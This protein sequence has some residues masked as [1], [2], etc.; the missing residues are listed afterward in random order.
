MNLNRNRKQTAIC[1]LE[2][3]HQTTEKLGIPKIE[4]KHTKEESKHKKNI[5]KLSKLLPANISKMLEETNGSSAR[6]SAVQYMVL[7]VF[8]G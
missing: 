7:A 8:D 5:K 2:T 6:H 1:K 4:N 3:I